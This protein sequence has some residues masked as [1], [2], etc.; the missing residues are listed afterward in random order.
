[1]SFPVCQSRAP[2]NPC[3]QFD[4]FSRNEAHR[5]SKSGS[6]SRHKQQMCRNQR[7]P[8]RLMKMMPLNKR[9]S[10][11]RGRT[12]V[13][14]KKRLKA[15]NLRFFQPIKITHQSSKSMGALNHYNNSASS[16]SMGP[17]PKSDRITHNKTT[18]YQSPSVGDNKECELEWE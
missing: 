10:S 9:L 12:K 13:L 7:N 2:L 11:T 1:M 15:Y 6:T 8:V 5:R 4:R 14:R 18:R 3:H 17:E 16:C